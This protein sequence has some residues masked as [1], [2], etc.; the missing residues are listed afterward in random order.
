MKSISALYLAQARQFLRDRMALIFVLLLPVG[1][2]VFFGVIFSGSSSFE[3]NIG[4]ANQDRGPAGAAFIEALP[5]DAFNLT[6]G[7]QDEL[8]EQLWKGELH[9]VLVLPES[10]SEDLAS[11]RTA[12]IEVLYDSANPTASGIGLGM[13]S[14]LL[15]EANLSMSGSPRTLEMVPRSVQVVHLRSVDFYLPGMLGVA[16]LW[17]GV[18]GTAQPFAAQRETKVYRRLQV[19]PISKRT[20]LTAEVSWRVTLGVLQ[21][22]IF[23]LVGYLAFQ[24]GVVAWLPFI[25]TVLLGTLVFVSLGYAIAGIG[26]SQESTMGIAQ[27]INF[28]MMMLSG[29]IISADMLPSFFKSVVQVM[30]LTYLSDLLRQTM[31]GAPGTY[32]MALDFAILG[33]WLVVLLGLAV[34]LW[35]W[36]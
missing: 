27:L 35:R 2:G 12:Q 20:I 28:P 11:G 33:A 26:R 19:T 30:P 14:T 29:S 24:V 36:E 23:L 4:V 10:M 1:F 32:P 25:G 34:W 6:A 18:F 22:G 3:L 21:A 13:V 9:T 31:V 17:L 8:T 15:S 5:G 7:T 16:L